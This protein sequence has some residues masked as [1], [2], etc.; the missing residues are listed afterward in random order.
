MQ[1]KIAAQR[2]SI[3]EADDKTKEHRMKM[4]EAEIEMKAQYKAQK[5][6]MLEYQKS[7]ITNKIPKVERYYQAMEREDMMQ[8]S[9]LE[10][11]MKQRLNR[12]GNYGIKATGKCK[13]CE[14]EGTNLYHAFHKVEPV[15]S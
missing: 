10:K 7:H 9:A 12:N 11:A 13:D 3:K 5:Q 14:A 15:A 6:M 8:V 1:N 2:K 4:I